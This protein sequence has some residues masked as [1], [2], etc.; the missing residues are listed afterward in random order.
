MAKVQG[1][2][3]VMVAIGP[4]GVPVHATC[5]SGPLLL[6][7]DAM[8]YAMGWT[9]EPSYRNGVAMPARFKLTLPYTLR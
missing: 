1:T 8:R 3:V 6:A 5:A 4:D 2:V 7:E 9:F